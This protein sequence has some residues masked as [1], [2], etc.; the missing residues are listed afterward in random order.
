MSDKSFNKEDCFKRVDPSLGM[1][2]THSDSF[3]VF[4]TA[5]GVNTGL[6]AIH[7]KDVHVICFGPH[8]TPLADTERFGLFRV[9]D[10]S[11][12]AFRDVH[13]NTKEDCLEMRGWAKLIAPF[14]A[15]KGHERFSDAHMSQDWIFF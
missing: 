12:E 14:N 13:L 11:C 10:P 2:S 4:C 5:C 7:K 1:I 9:A 6:G 3:S 15:S 8:Y